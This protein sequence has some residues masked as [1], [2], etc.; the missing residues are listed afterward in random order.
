MFTFWELV[1]V[2]IPV[3][4]CL[5]FYIVSRFFS[6]FVPFM[7]IV[8]REP[9]CHT[10]WVIY[11]SVIGGKELLG[12]EAK[13][14]NINHVFVCTHTHLYTLS[15]WKNVGLLCILATST[16]PSHFISSRVP[17]P[18]ENEYTASVKSARSESNMAFLALRVA[19]WIIDCFS[20]CSFTD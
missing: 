9:S 7:H 8:R 14:M 3:T 11:D 20:H 17:A 16:P 15:V 13:I 19:H 12:L 2:H 5:S 6:L 4:L 18:N 10:L 1:C